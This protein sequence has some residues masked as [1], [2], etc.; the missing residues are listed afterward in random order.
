MK[1][2][3]HTKVIQGIF[4]P[5]S[6]CRVFGLFDKLSRCKTV[7]EPPEVSNNLRILEDA[8]NVL[9]HNNFPIKFWQANDTNR[10]RI[11]SFPLF[12]PIFYALPLINNDFSFLF[13]LQQWL[14]FCRIN[15]L[16]SEIRLCSIHFEPDS[17]INPTYVM[18]G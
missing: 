15:E 3:W 13:R 6:C 11:P 12:L 9:L 8:K 18:K 10:P 16:S 4:G 5:L 14:R 2:F 7:F 17:F 1:T